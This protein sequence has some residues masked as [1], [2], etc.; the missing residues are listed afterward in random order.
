MRANTKET[1]INGLSN[2][3]CLLLV[4]LYHYSCYCLLFL[5]KLVVVIIFFWIRVCMCMCVSVISSDWKIK[6][7]CV[8]ERSISKWIPKMKLRE[9]NKWPKLPWHERTLTNALHTGL[10]I[11]QMQHTFGKHNNNGSWYDLKNEKKNECFGLHL[12]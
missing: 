9:T 4:L 3:D 7:V 1:K 5:L 2:C 6:C 10:F 8:A 12:R 11:R